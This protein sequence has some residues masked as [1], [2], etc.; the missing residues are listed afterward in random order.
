MLCCGLHP[1]Q[2]RHIDNEASA[3][4]Q[5]MGDR[6]EHSAAKGSAIRQWL[7]LD[8]SAAQ[9]LPALAP[10]P[11][12]QRT[13]VIQ[14]TKTA[15]PPGNGS[16]GMC[17]VQPTHRCSLFKAS[18]VRTHRT[19]RPPL[20]AVWKYQ[21]TQTRTH[22]EQA[23]KQAWQGCASPRQVTCTCNT[24]VPATPICAANRRNAPSLRSS[25]H[26]QTHGAERGQHR[27]RSEGVHTQT[28]AQTAHTHNS[29]RAD[30]PSLNSACVRCHSPC[31]QAG[32][33]ILR[34]IALLACAHNPPSLTVCVCVLARRHPLVT[35]QVGSLLPMC[36]PNVVHMPTGATPACRTRYVCEKAITCRN[37]ACNQ[38]SH[39]GGK[40]SAK[41]RGP[42]K[43]KSLSSS[44]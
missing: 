37:P 20:W 36:V 13:G 8:S 23:A 25:A 40:G 5:S 3:S 34:P 27:C 26:R 29:A 32:T 43:N 10:P 22:T 11:V 9:S 39:R 2:S 42:I 35:Q 1:Q 4:P 15:D 14:G 24:H 21:S 6:Q 12:C 30:T 33:R 44:R 7:V 16:A 19:T 41:S 38:D 17:C 28:E 18:T 31:S